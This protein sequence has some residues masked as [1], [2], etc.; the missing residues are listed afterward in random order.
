MA[1]TPACAQVTLHSQYR[2]DSKG[3]CRIQ[4]DQ[5]T[6]PSCGSSC[7]FDC[8]NLTVSL[9][10]RVIVDAEG[11]PISAA[12]S[13]WSMKLRARFTTNDSASADST[14]VDVPELF[15]LPDPRSGKLRFKQSILD[16]FFNPCFP[17]QH[18]D[19]CTAT[20]LLGIRVVD[21]N[22]QC[23]CRNRLRDA[24]AEKRKTRHLMVPGLLSPV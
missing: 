18:L 9:K 10:C 7:G 4:L 3:S 19:P 17:N 13:G 6:E 21:P 15:G 14:I 16:F 2:F 1:S 5:R 8:T 12:D 23:F 24:L 20:E 11:T 22:G